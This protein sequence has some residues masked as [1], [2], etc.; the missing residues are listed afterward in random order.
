MP[1]FTIAFHNA[2]RG[3]HSSCGIYSLYKVEHRRTYWPHK[4]LRGPF[5]S[6]AA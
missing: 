3:T 4:S 5:V 6:P 2:R 1:I